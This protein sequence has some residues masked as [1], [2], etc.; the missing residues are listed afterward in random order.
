MSKP[1]TIRVDDQLRALLKE[2]AE[3]EGTTVT[4]L[5]SR[6]AHDA[7]RDP[8]LAVAQSW[9]S[10]SHRNGPQTRKDRL[11]VHTSHVQRCAP[12]SASTATSLL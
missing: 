6:A 7:V 4:A 5:I 1:V 9:S 8:R 11:C 10:L 2:R 12:P 3:A